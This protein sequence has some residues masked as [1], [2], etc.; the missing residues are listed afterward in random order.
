[1]HTLKQQSHQ[2]THSFSYTKNKE[3]PSHQQMHIIPA[4]LN[5]INKQTTTAQDHHSEEDEKVETS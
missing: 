4:Q 3:Q 2:S 5:Y 1:M